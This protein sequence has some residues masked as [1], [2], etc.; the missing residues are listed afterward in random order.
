MIAAPDSTESSKKRARC[1]GLVRFF[2]HVRRE[3]H[4]GSTH[5]GVKHAMKFEMRTTRG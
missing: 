3:L 5:N 2:E 4:G 1:R